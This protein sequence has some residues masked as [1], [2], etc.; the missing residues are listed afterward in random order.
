MVLKFAVIECAGFLAEEKKDS[1]CTQRL[2]YREM[3][4]VF[5]LC[6]CDA[7]AATVAPPRCGVRYLSLRT[8]SDNS[9][10]K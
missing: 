8:F 1:V 10:A 6:S 5:T 2:V 9:G 4:C 7:C 3:V